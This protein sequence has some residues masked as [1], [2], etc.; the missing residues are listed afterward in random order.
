VERALADLYDVIITDF[1]IAGLPPDE[2]LTR[3]GTAAPAMPGVIMSGARVAPTRPPPCVVAFVPKP[4][5][6]AELVG[7]VEWAGR[8]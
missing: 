8:S 7:V 1:G 4:F 5:A 2:L 6:Q 3:A